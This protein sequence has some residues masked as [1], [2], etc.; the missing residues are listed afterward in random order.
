MVDGDVYLNGVEV[1]TDSAGLVKALIVAHAA[2]AAY[3]LE[4]VGAKGALKFKANFGGTHGAATPIA[5]TG[6]LS[7]GRNTP[8]I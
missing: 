3:R 4:Y 2:G 8:A 6:R 1:D 5:A 7:H